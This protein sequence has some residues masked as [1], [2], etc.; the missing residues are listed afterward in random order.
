MCR[1]GLPKWLAG[2]IC[3]NNLPNP[4]ATPA[5]GFSL[6]ES[7][8]ISAR[9]ID[10]PEKPPFPLRIPKQDPA[11]NSPPPSPHRLRITE[12]GEGA[13]SWPGSP[14][15]PEQVLFLSFPLHGQFLHV[16]YDRTIFYTE[17]INEESIT[18]LLLEEGIIY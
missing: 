5:R 9:G 17:R 4:S 1:N 18:I 11:R 14:M 2:M 12:E 13:G 10:L 16:L 8:A 7:G 15:H 6:P 3:Q